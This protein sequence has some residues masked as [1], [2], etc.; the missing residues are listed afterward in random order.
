VKEKYV[1]EETECAERD[2]RPL[3]RDPAPSMVGEMGEKRADRVGESEG[4]GAARDADKPST[5]V[6]SSVRRTRRLQKR[7]RGKDGINNRMDARGA[8]T[9]SSKCVGGWVEQGGRGVESRQGSEQVI[10]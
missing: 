9:Q 1:G 4:T 3:A 6:R 2:P 5:W 10:D 7:E 8:Y